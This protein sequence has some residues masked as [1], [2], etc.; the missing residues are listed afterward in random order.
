MDCNHLSI[1]AKLQLLGHCQKGISMCFIKSKGT[2]K[3]REFQGN[4]KHLGDVLIVT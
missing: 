2:M 4:L 3:P 1:K